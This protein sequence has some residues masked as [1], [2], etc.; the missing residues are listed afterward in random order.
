MVCVCVLALQ[1]KAV[2]FFSSTIVLSKHVSQQTA[3]GL[4]L[5][6]TLGIKGHLCTLTEFELVKF[7]HRQTSP[8]QTQSFKSCF[9]S[10]FAP[11][12][13]Q[14]KRQGHLTCRTPAP[15]RGSWQ[16]ERGSCSY[17]QQDPQCL[18]HSDDVLKLTDGSADS[19]VDSHIFLALK[20]NTPYLSS[21]AYPKM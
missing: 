6:R 11:I 14:A 18:L 15:C 20:D 13:E 7:H 8:V 21:Q 3:R 12:F 10:K 5:K 1:G 9:R 17:S 16:K 2:G 4:S 19:P